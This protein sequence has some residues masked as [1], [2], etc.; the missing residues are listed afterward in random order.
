MPTRPFS[1]GIPVSGCLDRQAFTAQARLYMRQTGFLFTSESHLKELC[2]PASRPQAASKPRL[3][4]RGPGL[5]L[6]VRPSGSAV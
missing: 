5:W 2:L 3:Y 1:W 6:D 4:Q